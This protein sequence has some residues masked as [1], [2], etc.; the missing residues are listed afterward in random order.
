MALYVAGTHFAQLASIIKC[1]ALS[2]LVV[3]YV[4]SHKR[5]H[6]IL[7]LLLWSVLHC[8]DLMTQLTFVRLLQILFVCK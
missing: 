8:G 3:A 1:T 7:L 6:I 5:L 2:V 4:L